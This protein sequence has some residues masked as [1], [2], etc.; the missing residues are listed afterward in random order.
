M[1][2]R[3]R[4]LDIILSLYEEKDNYNKA[5]LTI[6]DHSMGN[7]KTYSMQ[8]KTPLFSDIKNKLFEDYEVC[9]MVKQSNTIKTEQIVTLDDWIFTKR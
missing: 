7:E 4:K 9:F 1:E 6:V 2:N 3:T 8:I 5:F